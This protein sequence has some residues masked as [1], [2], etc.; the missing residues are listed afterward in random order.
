MVFRE[1][2]PADGGRA[3]FSDV[4]P[5]PI[6][7]MARISKNFVGTHA[8]RDVDLEFLAGEVHALVG[9]NGAGKSTLMRVLAG[10][11]ADYSGEIFFDGRPTKLHSPRLAR[12]LGIAMVHQELSLVPELSV[13]EN[14][15]LG[16]EA[17]SRIPGLIN[18]HQVEKQAGAILAEIEAGIS[19]TQRVNQLSIAK[20]QL[21]EIAKGIS[22]HSRVL[23]LDEPTS[24]LTEPEIKDLFSVIRSAKE[25][26]VAVIYISHKLPEIFAISDRI[27]VMRDGVKLST[28]A[29]GEWNEADLVRE[30]VGRTLAEFFPRRHRYLREEPVIEVSGLTQ[31]A[32]FVDVSFSVH[33]GE[34]LG[35]YGLVG[36]GRTRLAKTIFGLSQPDSGH[37]RING[38]TVEIRTPADALVNKI[39]LVPEDRRVLGLI[40]M[41]DVGKNLTLAHLKTLSNLVFINNREEQELVQENVTGLNIRAPSTKVPVSA[42]SGGNQQKVV[43]GKW[44][45]TKPVV[46]ILDEPTRGID[47]GAKAEIRHKI[48]A[49]ATDGMAI[50]L[51]SSELPEIMGM[52]DRILVMREKRIGGE[53]SRAEFSE[54]RIGSFA[55]AGRQ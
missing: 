1:S 34:I 35:I 18:R 4:T 45:S 22:M 24:S 32:H 17:P 36:S 10:T 7:R 3:S 15:F 25:K 40:Q 52:S 41:L 54:E 16:R 19:P 8:V 43:L 31:S 13:A 46:L 47:V 28:R 48:D 27:T 44:L 26:G 12:E 9:E 42:L 38:R 37:I 30:M 21:V 20:Q 23:I 5:R 6:V 39:A 53:F 50:L 49:L 11:Y 2:S 33:R 29:I 51:I 55:I 14:M